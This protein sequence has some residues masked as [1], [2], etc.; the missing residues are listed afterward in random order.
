MGFLG[1]FGSKSEASILKKHAPRIANKRAQAIDRMDSIHQVGRLGTDAAV[2]A[3]LPRFTFVVDP[4]I[5]DQEEKDATLRAIVDA[6]SNAVEPT[7]R[8][9]LKAD[10]IAWPLKI[11]E[12][13]LSPEEVTSAL[14]ELLATMDLEYE[15][16]PQKKIQ[17]LA[18]LEDRQDPRIASEVARFLEDINE[19]C[20]FHAVGA[21]LCQPNAQEGKAALEKTFIQEESVR[22]RARILDGFIGA[23]W[24]LQIPAAE[25]TP[26]LP[27][28]Y[29]L[30]SGGKPRKS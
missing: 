8:F 11:L 5:T 6:G 2:A 29:A 7:R 26:L 14:L 24:K 4:T 22:V 15:R 30:D 19:T 12:Q 27:S 13:L 17:T 1:L 23:Q 3:L 10:S 25:A 21:V 16:D 20:R 9:M 28:G 18:A